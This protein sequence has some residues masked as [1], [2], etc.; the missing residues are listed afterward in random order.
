MKRVVDKHLDSVM[1]DRLRRSLSPHR[2][3]SE[4]MELQALAR[5]APRK[6]S[7]TLSL[8]ADNRFQIRVT[9]LEES[10]LMENLQKIANRIT[11]GLIIAAL[12][13]AAAMMMRIETKVTLFGYPALALVMFLL[14]AALGI[15]VVLSA[16]LRDRR[17][18]P[19]E[20]PGPRA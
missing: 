14:A 10:R 18:R 15:G 17:A 19:R 5:E 7:D 11:T 6:L 8:L 9:G 1:G 12:L 3:A 13:V 20:E 16:L 4:M 2:V